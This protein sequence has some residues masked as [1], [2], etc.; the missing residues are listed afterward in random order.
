MAAKKHDS[1]EEMS[2]FSKHWKRFPVL[3]DSTMR[4][5][6]FADDCKAAMHHMQQCYTELARQCSLSID[7]VKTRRLKYKDAVTKAVRQFGQDLCQGTTDC[8]TPAAVKLL[9]FSGS[10]LSQAT[11]TRTLWMVNALISMWRRCFKHA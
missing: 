2:L 5:K 11:T 10:C 4:N 8:P 6:I 7:E 9:V 3:Y 1:V